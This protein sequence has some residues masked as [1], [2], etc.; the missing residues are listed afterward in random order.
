MASHRYSGYLAD[1][2]SLRGPQMSHGRTDYDWRNLLRPPSRCQYRNRDSASSASA[3]SA[4][5]SERGKK[6]RETTSGESSH[7]ANEFSEFVEFLADEDVLNSLQNIV[8][9]AVRKLCDVTTEDGEHVF[10]LQEDSSSSPDSASWSFSYSHTCGDS[11]S[12]QSQSKYNTAT[13]VTTTTTT[14]TT[15]SSDDDWERQYKRMREPKVDGRVCLLNKYASRLPK[16]RKTSA[17]ASGGFH[18]E[19][20]SQRSRDSYYRQERFHIWAKLAEAFPCQPPPKKDYFSKFQ[21]PSPKQSCSIESLHKEITNVL[22]RPTHSSIP[23]YY[24]GYQP[25]H[26]LDFLEENKILAA[27][28][29][30]I[31]QAVLRVL[32]ATMTD[33]I[34]FLNLFDEHGQALMIWDTSMVESEEEEEEEEEEKMAPSGSAETGSG[35]ESGSGSGE[36]DGDSKSADGK[37]KKR[38]GKSKKK[39]KVSPLP[40]EEEKVKQKYTPPPLP[41]SKRKSMVPE[42]AQRKPKYVPP[43]LPKSKPRPPPEE[44]PPKPKYVPPPLPKPKQKKQ[45]S[46]QSDAEPQVK[47]RTLSKHIITP[48]DIKRARLQARPLPK[49]AIIDF[50][51]EN[52]AKLFI[53]KYNYE[54]LLSEKLGFISV[55]VTKVLLEIMFGYKRIKGSGI[56]LSSQIDW[57]KV[58]EEIYAPRPPKPKIPKIKSVDKKKAEEKKK[59]K[60]AEEKKTTITPPPT[61]P[62]EKKTVLF[63]PGTPT[64]KVVLTKTRV[65]QEV[66]PKKTKEKVVTEQEGRQGPKTV[67]QEVAPRKT[68]KKV[69]TEQEG[70]QELEIYE[71]LPPQVPETPPETGEDYEGQTQSSTTKEPLSITNDSSRRSVTS[72][73]SSTRLSESQLP[74]V[75]SKQPSSRKASTPP[76]SKKTPM[77]VLPEVEPAD[78]PPGELLKKASS[79]RKASINEE[80]SKRSTTSLPKIEN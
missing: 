6:R 14:T 23:L 67:Q 64:G 34:P 7:V 9:D 57:S 18:A 2:E 8:E 71:L 45:D 63:R 37:K 61:K 52:A 17:G 51:I 42:E 28:Q 22:K 54:T 27:L 76:E 68:K 62:V 11:S 44:P 59:K 30:I 78:Q 70:R 55:P 75:S 31:N 10:D 56:R 73:F 16:L 3:F 69:V 21:K 40:T 1:D 15:S 36:E 66:V 58:Y 5:T 25:F 24:P 72:T 49:Q 74:T 77:T 29:D 47:Q 33:G 26:A 48:K 19:T 46:I 60:K 43:P 41:K 80:D 4:R 12:A 35:E 65:E 38:K 79:S 20:F 53:Y 13:T 39:K 50:L 32:E